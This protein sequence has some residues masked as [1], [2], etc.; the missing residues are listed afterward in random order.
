MFEFRWTVEQ[1][2]AHTLKLRVETRGEDGQWATAGWLLLR[3]DEWDALRA[4]IL[5]GGAGELTTYLDEGAI[6]PGIS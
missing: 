2:R 6:W 4:A 1:Q 3:N 5:L